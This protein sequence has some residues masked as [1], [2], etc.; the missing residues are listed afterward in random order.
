MS[1]N[2]FKF[3]SDTL[4][5]EYKGKSKK[6]VA[7]MY[8]M[9]ILSASVVFAVILFFGFS[10]YINSPKQRRMRNEIKVLQDQYKEVVKKKKQA[11]LYLNELREKDRKIYKALFESEPE[12]DSSL[13]YNPYR[14]FQNKEIL[15]I[16]KE[17]RKRLENLRKILIE[18]EIEC[19]SIE[20]L[21]EEKNGEIENI[22]GIQPLKNKNLKHPVYGFG[23]RIDPVYKSPAFHSGIDFMATEGTG[24]YATANG[25]VIS[26][27]LERARGKKISIDHGNGYITIYAHL[28]SFNVSPGKKVKRGDLIGKVGNTGKSFIPHLHYE[29]RYNNKAVNPVSY[30]FLDLSPENYAKIRQTAAR[31]GL[32]LD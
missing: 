21:L 18:Q 29:I 30:F 25:K 23:N 4:E 15:P 3:N 1:D 27:R 8:I 5:Y 7:V 13:T 24:V 32:S 31:A 10:K 26:I 19:R 6:Q 9:T 2:K 16:A 14:K 17:N 11:D 12:E 28:S 20:T 22:P